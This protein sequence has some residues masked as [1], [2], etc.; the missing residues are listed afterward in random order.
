[1]TMSHI[2]SYVH[3]RKRQRSWQGSVGSFIRGNGLCGGVVW[4]GRAGDLACGGTQKN[5][6]CHMLLVLGAGGVRT[7]PL[8]YTSVSRGDNLHLPQCARRGAEAGYGAV[9]GSQRL[10]ETPAERAP[11]EARQLLDPVLERMLAAVLGTKAR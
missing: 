7:A 5:M 11:E 10:D 4:K 9:C 6:A 2:C 3:Y 1:M 8:T